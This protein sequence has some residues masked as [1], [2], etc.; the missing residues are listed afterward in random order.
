[1]QKENE[2]DIPEAFKEL[3]PLLL[4]KALEIATDLSRKCDVPLSFVT[5]EALQ[6]AILWGQGVNGQ[7]RDDNS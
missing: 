5:D 7:A 6:R 2:G 1:M 4:A 3:E